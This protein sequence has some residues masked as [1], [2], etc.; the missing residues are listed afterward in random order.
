ME[1]SKWALTSIMLNVE[2]PVSLN[3]V[4]SFHMGKPSVLAQVGQLTLAFGRR[5]YSWARIE[6]V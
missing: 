1:S 6:F 4:S 5:S 3:R 2:L